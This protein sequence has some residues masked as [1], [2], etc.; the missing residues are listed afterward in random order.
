M[1]QGRGVLTQHA[2]D[3]FG[4]N[5]A[6]S[7]S[8]AGAVP[9]AAMANWSLPPLDPRNRVP[10]QTEGGAQTWWA[11]RENGEAEWVGAAPGGDR[12]QLAWDGLGMLAAA[13]GGGA[14]HDFTYAPSGLRAGDR[15]TGASPH[16]RRFV[17]ASSGQLLSVR[18]LSPQGQV[19]SRTDIVYANGTA[20][21]EVDAD[22]N[23][24]ELH[25]DHLGS[26]RY[27]TSGRTGALAGEQAFG[28]YGERME[29][30]PQ[31][32]TIGLSY[33]P[34]TGYT[35]HICE[36]GTGLIY[37]RAR[38]YSPAWHRF[39]SSDRGADRGALNQYAYVGGRVFAAVDPSGLTECIYS[40]VYMED[41]EWREHDVRV[42][43]CDDGWGGLWPTDLGGAGDWGGDWGGDWDADS[44]WYW[45]DAG[46]EFGDVTAAIS[47]ISIKEIDRP[48]KDLPEWLVKIL[49][50]HVALLFEFTDDAYRVESVMNEV[51]KKN[52]A[53]IT[54]GT[55]ESLMADFKPG[56]TLHSSQTITYNGLQAAVNYWNAQNYLYN[57]VIWSSRGGLGNNCYGFR[58]YLIKEFGLS[59]DS[60]KPKPR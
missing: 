17:Y 14:R 52:K 30:A 12:L 32:P 11:Y 35:G 18:A 36:D 50:K 28:P 39:V 31:G 13:S 10:A 24:F 44:D 9:P 43:G 60:A 56:K 16:D 51:S 49:P 29:V 21:A 57:P 8:A 58:N 5:I 48:L 46:W 59:Y 19:I 42:E 20:L 6:H 53:S 45:L 3:G 1:A 26:P 25:T 47:L 37:M 55:V 40:V 54:P 41:G 7:A 15:R 38:Y 22:G 33:R 2:H 27:I 34:V 23:V 4:N